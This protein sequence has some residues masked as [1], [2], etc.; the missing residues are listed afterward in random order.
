[1]HPFFDLD[2]VVL[3]P[4]IGG[5]VAEAMPRLADTT[6]REMLAVLRGER[7]VRLANPEVWDSPVRRACAP[8]NS[9]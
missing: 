9:A 7:P 1:M 2:N 5:W 3:T 6:A 8:E 4:H